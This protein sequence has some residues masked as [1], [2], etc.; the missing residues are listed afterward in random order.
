MRGSHAE[1]IVVRAA[2]PE[3]ADAVWPLA[4][5][6]ATSFVPDRSTFDASWARVL[7]MPDALVM[8]AVEADAAKGYLLAFSHPTFYANASV[9]WVEEILVTEEARG[10]GVGRALMDAAEEWLRAADARVLALATRRA[11]PFYEALGYEGSATYFK[12]TL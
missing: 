6:L 3:D 7:A 10:L 11:A 4:R 2:L 12:K 9:G 5:D 1:D 8:V